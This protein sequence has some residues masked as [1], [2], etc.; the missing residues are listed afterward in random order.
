MRSS[1]PYERVDIKKSWT[2]SDDGAISYSEGALLPDRVAPMHIRISF[3]HKGGHHEEVASIVHP[4]HP[5]WLRG[6]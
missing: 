6:Q 4:S 2:A 3:Q 1:D 5:R